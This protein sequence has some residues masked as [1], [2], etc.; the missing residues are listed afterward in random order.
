MEIDFPCA[1]EHL[2]EIRAFATKELAMHPLT[3][4][5]RAMLIGAV[6]E[7]C[8]NIIIHGNSLD[9]RKRIHI[10]IGRKGN[11]MHINT[12]DSGLA[13]D[14][15]NRL[16]KPISELIEAKA[17][18]GLGLVIISKAADSFNYERRNGQNYFSII[19]NLAV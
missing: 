19:K 14:Q 11:A 7:L 17:R 5:E 12:C 4:R 16:S 1:L 2:T 6:D 3:A 10:F 15:T 18:G 9:V 8:A 13:F